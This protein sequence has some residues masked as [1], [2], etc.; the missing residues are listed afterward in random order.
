MNRR[1]IELIVS[2]K[3]IDKECTGELLRILDDGGLDDNWHFAISHV[4]AWRQEL[5]YREL[6]GMSPDF[7]NF[8]KHYKEAF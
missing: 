2:G 6:A 5:R 7:R 8:C 4:I 3:K 1:L